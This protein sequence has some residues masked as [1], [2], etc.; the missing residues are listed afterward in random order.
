MSEINDWESLAP[1]YRMERM[2]EATTRAAVLTRSSPAV[3]Q[4]SKRYSSSQASRVCVCVCMHLIYA[5]RKVFKRAK[6]LMAFVST[7]QRDPRHSVG[8]R[9]VCLYKRWYSSSYRLRPYLTLPP[10]PETY[11]VDR[12]IARSQKLYSL[13]MQER[14]VISYRL[15]PLRRH[16]VVHTI[17]GL[18]G[19]TQREKVGG[20]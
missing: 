10:L 19:R 2:Q 12:P 6:L 4:D 15:Y 16:E 8:G 20:Q 14:L 18:H 17:L 9:E 5:V 7:D 11:V 1:P 3:L 13:L